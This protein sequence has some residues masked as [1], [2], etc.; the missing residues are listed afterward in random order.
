M[1]WMC[2]GLSPAFSERVAISA[3]L[4]DFGHFMGKKQSTTHIKV[5]GRII[6]ISRTLYSYYCYIQV[7]SCCDP[8]FLA[9]TVHQIFS[10]SSLEQ[11][12]EIASLVVCWKVF[13]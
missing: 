8:P 7:S 13:E 10:L 4:H 9:I 12:D 11:C 5:A 3:K 6:N 2:V 1:E